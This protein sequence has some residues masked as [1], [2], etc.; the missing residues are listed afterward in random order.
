MAGAAIT[1]LKR[2]RGGYKSCL[3][4][5]FKKLDDLAVEKSKDEISLNSLLSNCIAYMEN[6]KTLDHEIISSIE[7]ETQLDEFCQEC[8]NYRF[9]ANKKIEEFKFYVFK[10]KKIPTDPKSDVI[11][12][13]VN[14]FQ[15]KLG[16]LSLPILDGKNILDYPNWFDSFSNAVDKNNHITDVE[17]FT[18]LRMCLKE[19]A[20]SL[21]DGF[22]ISSKNYRAAFDIIKLRY[23]DTDEIVRAYRKAFKNIRVQNYTLDSVREL[24][25]KIQCYKRVLDNYDTAV[26]TYES[27]IFPEIFESL[28]QALKDSLANR[29][30][31]IK[32]VDCRYDEFCSTLQK[33]IDTLSKTRPNVSVEANA[34]LLARGTT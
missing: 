32:N 15:T 1:K 8:D 4:N 18:R 12:P 21:I 9:T 22:T 33:V 26:N 30:S 29:A 5:S 14:N 25:S 11:S 3:T 31:N 16:K 34:A 2:S 19:P 13:K 10:L 24:S 28:P 17:K 23:G 7:D 6:I 20:L 27:I